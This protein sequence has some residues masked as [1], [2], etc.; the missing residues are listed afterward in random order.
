MASV[1]VIREFFAIR[2]SHAE[3]GARPDQTHP[4]MVAHALSEGRYVVQEC[5]TM[6]AAYIAAHAAMGTIIQD[7]PL[8]GR[9]MAGNGVEVVRAVEHEPVAQDMSEEEALIFGD[10][11]LPVT[12]TI[13]GSDTIPAIPHFASGKLSRYNP[14]NGWDVPKTIDV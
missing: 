13:T 10:A 14:V 3:F 9:S 8:K 7:G 2:Y 1:T 6:T 12:M 11:F 4:E 5:D